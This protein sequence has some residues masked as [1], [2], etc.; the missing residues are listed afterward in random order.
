MSKIST[1][2]NVSLREI[3]FFELKIE[4]LR[5]N[6]FSKETILNCLLGAQMGWINEI[7]N[8][9]KSRDTANLSERK[10]TDLR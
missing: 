6:E 7:K 2:R 1:L 10:V 3:Q 4:H 8:A 5:E 9:K